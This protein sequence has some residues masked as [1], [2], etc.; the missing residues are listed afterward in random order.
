[1][2]LQG[3]GGGGDERSLSSSFTKREAIRG[4]SIEGCKKKKKDAL[5][6]NGSGPDPPSSSDTSVYQPGFYR[7]F[8]SRQ[9]SPDFFFSSCSVALP[10]NS[11]PFLSF[12]LSFEGDE[13]GRRRIIRRTDR[14]RL[15]RNVVAW[16]R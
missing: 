12:F 5:Y 14:C 16:L 8:S 10:P 7:C 11:N 13:I 3:R 6:A 9:N 1:M 4:K 15:G 2:A